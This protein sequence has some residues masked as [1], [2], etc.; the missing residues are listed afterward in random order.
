MAS[1]APYAL[2]G[3]IVLTSAGA[4]LMCLLVIRYGFTPLDE[5]PEEAAHRLFLTRLA[6]AAA[7]VCFAGAA[8]LAVAAWSARS[9]P[10]GAA[11]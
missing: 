11:G 8:L 2:P 4:F 9:V 5:D 1:L 3:I 7:A 10:A 6:H